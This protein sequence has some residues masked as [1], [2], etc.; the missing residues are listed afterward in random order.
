MR[1]ISVLALGV[2]LAVP[3]A[4]CDSERAS[5]DQHTPGKY[6]GQIDPLLEKTKGGANDEAIKKRFAM[7]QTDR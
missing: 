2:F 1:V 4:G 6:T 7:I 3:L 5:V